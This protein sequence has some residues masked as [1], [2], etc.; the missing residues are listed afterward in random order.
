MK[1]GIS[2][3]K[4]AGIACQPTPVT[5]RFAPPYASSHSLIATSLSFQVSH[6][7][8]DSKRQIQ[9]SLAPKHEIMIKDLNKL[10]DEQLHK[11]VK[12]INE[13]KEAE[14]QNRELK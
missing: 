14:K 2:I 1:K 9:Q 5:K 10:V 3:F 13:K 7:V 4:G 11:V 12:K 6:Q 8:E